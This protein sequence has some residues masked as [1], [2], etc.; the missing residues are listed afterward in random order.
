[1]PSAG[2][3]GAGGSGAIL[4]A[5]RAFEPHGVHLFFKHGA[6]FHDPLVPAQWA[7]LSS[8][9]VLDDAMVRRVVLEEL[10]G[11]RSLLARGIYSPVPIARGLD[12]GRTLEGLLEEFR[13]EMIEVG[14]DQRWVWMGRPVAPRVK[15]FFLEHLGWEP[16]IGRWYF[17][18]QVNPEWWDKSY[19]EAAVT[20]VVALSVREEDGG[21]DATLNT[22]SSDRLD[23]A[24]L[25]L[26]RE[27][28]LF[29]RSARIGEVMFADTV[30]FSILRHANDA[31]DAVRIAGSWHALRWPDGG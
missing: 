5:A 10:A 20:P 23:L 19:L 21:L 11:R 26:D 13:Y 1:V 17:E 14:A 16:A 15:T 27:E 22:G 18:Y 25:R 2:E 9:P 3:A 29:C 30:R 6:H 28:R 7:A 4:T 8:D 12:A 24:T 31:C